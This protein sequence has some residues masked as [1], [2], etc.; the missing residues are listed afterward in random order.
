VISV[1]RAIGVLLVTCAVTDLS[2]LPASC[3]SRVTVDEPQAPFLLAVLRAALLSLC[4]VLPVGAAAAGPQPPC[5]GAIGPPSPA[6]G[7]LD[8]LPTSGAWRGADLRRE[9]WQPPAC[10]G[11]QGDSRII[12]AIATRFH[13]P[14]SLGAMAERLTAVSSHPSIRFW[15]TGLQEWLPLAVDA[16]AV[17]GPNGRMRLSDPPRQ[18]LMPGRELYYTE[19]MEVIGRVVF[20]VRVLEH[21]RDRLVLL[22]ENVTPIRV[23]VVTLFEPGALQVGSFLDHEES[24]GWKLYEITRA[25]AA[26]NF[27]VAG[28]PSSYLNRLDAMRRYIVGLPTDRDPPIAP[29]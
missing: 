6:Y 13:S 19:V 12:A 18:A 4:L 3:H 7:P 15:A 16:W 20:R 27:V 9:G 28:Y 21:T 26:S 23:A 1:Q 2:V 5:E 25:G 24:D 29:Q 8:G 11:W 22:T 17:D 14:L 10:L